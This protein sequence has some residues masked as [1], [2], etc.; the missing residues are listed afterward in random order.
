MSDV[1]P[2][3][4]VQAAWPGSPKVDSTAE[5]PKPRGAIDKLFGTTGERYQTWPERAIRDLVGAPKNLIDAAYSAPVGSRKLTTNLVKPATE[6]ALAFIPVGPESRA[7]QAGLKARKTAI[8]TQEE[9]ATVTTGAGQGYKGGIMDVPLHDHVLPDIQ[10]NVLD[11]LHTLHYRDYGAPF[12]FRAVKELEPVKGKIPTV[13]DI[14]TVRQVLG[15]APLDQRAAANVARNKINE[16]LSEIQPHDTKLG[17]NVGTTLSDIRGN[18]ASLKRSEQLGDATEKGHRAAQ[19]SGM[20]AN[21]DNALR[22]KIKEIRNNPKKS[23]GFSKEEL[24]MMDKVIKG[25]PVANLARMFSRFGPQHPLTGWGMATVE[26]L[27]KGFMW[28]VATLGGGHVAQ[29]IAENSTKKHIQALDEAVRSR[30]PLFKERQPKAAKP[31]VAD[32][33]SLSKAVRG[34]LAAGS[35]DIKAYLNENGL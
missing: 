21:L 32:S 1:W 2:G 6:T 31:K 23:R 20:G 3:Q 26:A 4:P 19:S 24:D 28:P 9:L 7:A 8:P 13:S 29:K 25:T 16:Y 14:E 27:K 12:V 5:S 17:E 35:P 34:T 18:Y 10:R 22:Q 15:N 11:D 30:S 33:A